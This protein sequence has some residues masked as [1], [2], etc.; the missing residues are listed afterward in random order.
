MKITVINGSPK[1]K[2]SISLQSVKYLMKY[3]PDVEFEIFDVGQKIK[4]IEKDLPSFNAILEGVRSSDVLLWC[5]PVYTFLVPYQL[6]RFIALIYER[7]AE[8]VFE[9]KYASQVLTSKHF[10]DHTAHNYLWNV[11]EDLGMKH[12]MGHCADMDDLE[13]PEGRK[14]LLQFG[15]ELLWTVNDKRPVPRR[16]LQQVAPGGYA[17]SPVTRFTP[18]LELD[19]AVLPVRSEPAP[20]DI[21]LVTD[22]SDPDSNLGRMIR[23]FETALANPLRVVN[24]NDFHFSGGCLGCFHCAFA[25]NCIYKDGF[26]DF[27]RTQI[28]SADCVIYAA[29][30]NHHWFNP[31]WK[32]YDDRQF[33]NGH[34]ISSMGKAIAYIIS[35]PLKNEANLREVIEARS[36]VARTYLAGIVT[37]EAELSAETTALLQDLAASTLRAV[38]TKASRPVNFLGAGGM[39]IFRDLIYVMRGLMQEDHRFYQQRGLYADFPQRQWKRITLMIFLGLLLKQKLIRGKVSS[40][41]KEVLLKRYEKII[42]KN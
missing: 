11:S 3:Y 15:A 42:S 12:I 26:D 28:R 38:A 21:V 16:F 39:K 2:Y 29:S 13:K 36:E 14:C 10:Y 34:R 4:H 17:G 20:Y 25:G 8:A 40:N 35:G 37:D 27:H 5:Y 33:Y 23:V 31:V 24:L 9:G 30:I 6:V 1:G 18:P 7:Q 19:E 32:C 22:C 41:F